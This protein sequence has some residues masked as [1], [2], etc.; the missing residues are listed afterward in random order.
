MYADDVLLLVLPAVYHRAVSLLFFFFFIYFA[1]FC[2]CVWPVRLDTRSSSGRSRRD[3]A[4]EKVANN[5]VLEN[6]TSILAGPLSRS[7]EL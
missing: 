6:N 1:V 5:H 4:E 3:E 2:L 7:G